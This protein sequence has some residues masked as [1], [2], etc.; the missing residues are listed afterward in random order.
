MEARSMLYG[1]KNEVH[2][3]SAP[4]VSSGMNTGMRAE[5]GVEN[6]VRVKCL[7]APFCLN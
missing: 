7:N 3:A 2:P 6:F 4:P 5:V 1:V